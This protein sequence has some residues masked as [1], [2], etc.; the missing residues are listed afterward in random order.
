MKNNF[1]SAFDS[2]KK[3]IFTNLVGMTTIIKVIIKICLLVW[4]SKNN[5][6]T[7]IQN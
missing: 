7:D 2:Y 4:I 6:H 5:S 3:Y 1:I